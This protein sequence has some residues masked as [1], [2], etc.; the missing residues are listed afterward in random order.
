VERTRKIEGLAPEELE[1]QTLDLL[2][3]REEMVV[4]AF[5]SVTKYMEQYNQG[6]QVAAS[7]TTDHSL[8]WTGNIN[9]QNNYGAN[10]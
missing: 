8:S 6:L 10:K 3:D 5:P 1:A 9:F 2:P 7:N 4:P